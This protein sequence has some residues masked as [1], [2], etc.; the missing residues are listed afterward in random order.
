MSHTPERDETF[1][2][3]G[4]NSDRDPLFK[5]RHDLIS[6]KDGFQSNLTPDEGMMAKEDAELRAKI[7]K[8]QQE[9]GALG[10]DDL[11]RQMKE[12]K[13]QQMFEEMGVNE[14]T[15]LLE[16][17]NRLQAEI[18]PLDLKDEMRKMKEQKISAFKDRLEEINK[19][20]DQEK[21]AA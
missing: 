8:L 14:S 15:F 10:A 16:E 19:N 2:N 1:N 21:L 3:L 12:G 7:L 17:I 5:E 11:M 13:I 4:Q 18:Y 9:I 20:S 6:D